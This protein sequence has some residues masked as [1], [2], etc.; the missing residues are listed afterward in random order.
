VCS[1]DLGPPKSALEK[2]GDFASNVGKWFQGEGDFARSE[3]DY[4]ELTKAEASQIAPR[5]QVGMYPFTQPHLQAATALARTELGKLNVAKARGLQGDIDKYGNAYVQTPDGPRYIN[6][7][8]ASPQDVNAFTF[9]AVPDIAMAYFGGRFGK[10][11]GGTPGRI[12]GSGAGAGTAIMGKDALGRLAGSNEKTNPYMVAFAGIMGMTGEALAPLVPLVWNWAA[13]HLRRGTEF[14]DNAGRLTRQGRQTLSRFGVDPDGIN[15]EGLKH[16]QKLIARGGGADDVA[17]QARKARLDEFDIRGSRGDYTQNPR[18]QAIEEDALMAGRQGESGQARIARFRDDQAKDIAR[19][20]DTIEKGLSGGK[21]KAVGESMDEARVKMVKMKKAESE[22]VTTKYTEADD[23]GGRFTQQ[24]VSDLNDSVRGVL[25]EYTI[26]KS[27]PLWQ[28]AKEVSAMKTFL[29]KKGVTSKGV[30]LKTLEGWRKRVGKRYKPDGSP[31]SSAALKI[32]RELDGIMDDALNGIK[33][34]ILAGNPVAMET[35]KQARAMARK[36][37]VRWDKDK[38]IRAIMD[39]EDIIDGAD[40]IAKTFILNPSEAAKK[41]F[42][43]AGQPSVGAEK[44]LRRMRDILGENSPEWGA[45]KS[46]AMF[47]M[48]PGD[49]SSMNRE[50]IIAASNK[51]ARSFQKGLKET[52]EY[53]VTLFGTDLPM[54]KRFALAL[55]DVGVRRAGVQNFSS[56]ANVILRNLGGFG[57]ALSHYTDKLLGPIVR[58]GRVSSATSGNVLPP[59]QLPAGLLGGGVATTGPDTFEEFFGGP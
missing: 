54:L 18:H 14:L 1:S 13:A 7:A 58:S 55:Q 9:E 12:V 46:E 49:M 15:E 11:V 44:A 59:A 6:R 43:V 32:Q 35:M 39:K 10:G 56:S 57:A 34:D 25:K 45:F 22:G 28:L 23:L 38:V 47:R 27:D 19:A 17:A 4:P 37:I 31:E 29:G 53:F 50:A 51:F 40:D 3:F 42:G 36:K 8:G 24:G 20:R 30:P 21:Q 41:L 5:K 48:F 33:D 26:G 52:P 2:I 16:I